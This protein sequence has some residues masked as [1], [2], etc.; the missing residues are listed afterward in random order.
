MRMPNDLAKPQAISRRWTADALLML[1][2]T[3]WGANILV[4]KHFT[5]ELNP[6]VF[7]AVR[8]VF[9]A[10]TL[11][12]LAAAETLF[13][14]RESRDS[15]VDWKRV[16]LFA[17]LSGFLYL[18][19][20]VKAIDLTTAGNTAL[21]LASMPMWTAI[22]SRLFLHERLRRIT[23]I[24]LSVTFV[25]TAIV[26]TQGSGEVSFASAYLI[27]NLLML[28]ASMT[29]AAGTVMSRSILQSMSPLRLAFVSC[30]LTTPFHFLLA[31]PNLRA[32]LPQLYESST[33]FAVVFSGA[34]STG[35][36]Y[37]T[38]HAGVRAVGGSHAAV[39]QN[40]VTL[41][42]VIGGWLVLKEQPM[43]SQVIGGIMTV[44]GLFLMRK[45]RE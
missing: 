37:A 36:A 15:A 42:A 26:T 12:L 5:H 23:W 3:I 21:I 9:A 28:L 20:F 11:G 27:G 40:V 4:F 13:L 19:I 1:T 25:G 8:L 18:V 14:P 30:V 35:I 38:W 22:L 43:S 24:G 45:G 29:W 6:W 17:F 2:A 32:S 41:V 7:N 31:A 16:T 44:V 39:Y 10:V 33:M 34:C